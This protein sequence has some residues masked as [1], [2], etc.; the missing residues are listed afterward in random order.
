[1]YDT[2]VREAVQCLANSINADD[3]ITIWEMAISSHWDRLP[4]WVHGNISTG[5]ILMRNGKLA[6]IIDFGG[7]CI[8]DPACDFAIAWTYFDAVS[9]RV[10]KE[11]INIDESTWL[12]GRA[13]ALWKALIIEAEVTDSNAVEKSQALRTLREIL[14]EN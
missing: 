9:R 6:A 3:A 10:F 7:L 2:Q 11:A 8:G 5:N 4:V 1:M 14:Y 13:W 12:R